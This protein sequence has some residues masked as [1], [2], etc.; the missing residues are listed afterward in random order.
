MANRNENHQLEKLQADNKRL[1]RENKNLRKLLDSS[2]H[3]SKNVTK[4][5]SGFFR[6]TAAAVLIAISVALLVAGNMLLWIGNTVV[7]TDQYVEA[8]APMVEDPV[9]QDAVAANLTQKLFANVNVEQ[10][11]EEALPPRAAFLA[12]TLAEQVKQK[13]ESTIK[14]IL[15]R[16]EFQERWNA[17]QK[18]SH[19]RF[20]RLVNEHGSDGSIDISEVYTGL[21]QQL[22]GTKLS[23][24]AD[25]PLPDKVANV[26]VVQGGWLTALQKTIAN[27]DTWRMLTIILI[28]L[29]G[30]LAIWLSR[31]RRRTAILLGLFSAVSLLIFALSMRVGREILA[32]KVD[33]QFAEASRHV[34]TIFFHSLVVQTFTLLACALLIAFIAWVSGPY[35]SSRKLRARIDQLFAGKLHKALFAKENSFTLWVGAHKSVL[36]WLSVGLVIGSALFIRLSPTV[37]LTQIIIILSIVFLLELFA[38]K[39]D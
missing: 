27:I 29:S 32:S 17:A 25:K 10:V 36:Q 6:K 21:S 35:S 18:R 31:N 4:D 7:N 24:L 8:T 19:E 16:P 38:A 15:T 11:A 30:A 22:K 1:E 37:L 33:P 5:R 9:I 28:V 26:Q 2:K 14:Q 3:S 23:F 34:Y 20:I 39:L 13:T 12:P